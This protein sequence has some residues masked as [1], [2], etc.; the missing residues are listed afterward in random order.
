MTETD[1]PAYRERSR[2]RNYEN[3]MTEIRRYVGSDAEVLARNT[4]ALG[5]ERPP[6]D[7]LAGVLGIDLLTADHILKGSL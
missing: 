6:R 4:Y 1:S 3:L 2:Q 7:E 5:G